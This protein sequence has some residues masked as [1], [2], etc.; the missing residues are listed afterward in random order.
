MQTLVIPKPKPT[1]PVVTIHGHDGPAMVTIRRD[2]VVEFGE[3]YDLAEAARLFWEG[4][5]QHMPSELTCE[6]A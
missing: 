3:D 4:V 6:S 5:A 1:D 2:G